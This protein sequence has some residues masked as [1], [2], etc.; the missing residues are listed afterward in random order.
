[1]GKKVKN[2]TK[3]SPPAMLD[4]SIPFK[5]DV[6]LFWTFQTIIATFLFFVFSMNLMDSPYI[7]TLTKFFSILGIYLVTDTVGGYASSL[8]VTA[9]FKKT[10]DTTYFKHWFTGARRN[11]LRL[12]IWWLFSASIYVLSIDSGLS[13]FIWGESTLWTDVVT[14]LMVKLI[15]FVLTA[16]I[17]KYL[18]DIRSSS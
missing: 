2:V 8:V 10:Y 14:Y 6:I 9:M 3:A 5:T 1:M 7:T 18:I 15:S 11:I 16:L 13:E 4:Q 17:T 12:V